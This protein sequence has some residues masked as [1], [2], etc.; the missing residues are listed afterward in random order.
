MEERDLEALVRRL[1]PLARSRPRAYR[2]R[3]VALAALGY[4]VVALVL[5]IILAFAA[6]IAFAARHE[7][8]VAARWLIPLSLLVAAVGKAFYVS[9]DPPEGMPLERSDVPELFEMIDEIRKAIGGPRVHAVL[10]N[11]N[12]NAGVVQVPRVSGLFGSRNYLVLGYPY[13][14]ALSAEELRS[15]IAHELGHL[16]RRHGRFGVFVYRVHARWSNLLDALDESKSAWRG[17]AR[18]F[19]GWYA[20]TFTAYAFPAMRAHELEADDAAAAVSGRAVTAAAL[21]S[22]TMAVRWAGESYWWSVWARV[23]D[24]P[25]PPRAAYAPMARQIGESKQGPALDIWY[26]DLLALATDATDS[27]PSMAD[28]LAHLEIEPAEALELA[29][30][31]GRPSAAAVYLGDAETRLV[32]AL[33]S[34]WRRDVTATWRGRH[35]EA[36][37][38]KAELSRLDERDELSAEEA[39]RRAELTETYCGTEA[40]QAR[41]AELIGTEDDAYARFAIGRLL[42][43]REDDEGLRWLEEAAAADPE[44]VISACEVAIAYLHVHDRE[45]EEQAYTNR[46]IEHSDRLEAADA[47]RSVVS[48]DDRLEPAGLSEDLLAQV[49]A[50]LAGHKEVACAYLV[51]KRVEH[52]DDTHPVYVLAVVPMSYG[53]TEWKDVAKDGDVLVERVARDIPADIGVLVV[54]VHKDAPLRRRFAEVDGSC[55]YEA[56]PRAA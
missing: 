46:M 33:D 7:P 48:A 35:I 5:L 6:G 56:R 34:E 22:G 18:R 16:S 44:A 21:V 2:Y 50:A 3:V 20:P 24:E 17:P 23:V 25:E 30:Q 47:E 13:L 36:E 14:A 10:L 19:A 11:G 12:P 54:T 15:V 37:A 53:R 42:L 31:E 9:S 27:H 52:F 55:V 39:R 51:R 1:E 49:R 8:V 40:G 38:E 4:L 41:Y 45:E 43:D 32:A 28:R 29:T 26:R